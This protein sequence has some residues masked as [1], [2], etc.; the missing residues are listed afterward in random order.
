MMKAVKNFFDQHNLRPFQS[1]WLFFVHVIALFGLIY[2]FSDHVLFSK[3]LLTHCILHNLWGLG[4]TAGAHRLW[5]HKSYQASFLWKVIV[6]ILNSGKIFILIKVP[7]K[8][9]FFTGAETIDSITNFPIPISIHTP[10]RKD[11]SL[12][13]V[14][15]S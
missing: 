15:G 13:T 14:D 4:I 7:I 8:G 12:P 9:P 2:A 3:I 5:A 6:M 1:I 11:F 10:L